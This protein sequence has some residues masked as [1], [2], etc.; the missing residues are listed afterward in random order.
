MELSKID[1]MRIKM[2][3]SDHF[4][5]CTR[6]NPGCVVTKGKASTI[7]TDLLCRRLF[8]KIIKSGDCPCYTYSHKEIKAIVKK[9]IGRWAFFC[10]Y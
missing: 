3:T 7:R 1:I 10:R 5:G 9:A 2:A 4:T 6:I 8:P